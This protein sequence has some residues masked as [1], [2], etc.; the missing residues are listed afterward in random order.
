MD[1]KKMKFHITITN[2]ETG[3]TIH[4]TDAC[5]ILASINVGSTTREVQAVACGPEEFAKALN[6]AESIVRHVR[7]RYP[8]V[9]AVAM[10][11]GLIS[12]AEKAEE[13]ENKE[14]TEAQEDFK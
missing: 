9:G 5:A 7:D 14:A 1:E 4:D 8:E 2:N 11:L 12:K 6:G 13:P 3:E 10:L